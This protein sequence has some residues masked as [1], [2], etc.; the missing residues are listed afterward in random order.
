MNIKDFDFDLPEELIA[1]TPLEKRDSSKL[2]V[3]DRKT[4][5]MVDTHFDHILDELNPGDALVMN[6]TRV[7]PARLYGEKPDTHGHVEL[8]LLKNT[9][10]DQWEVLAKPAKRL[11]VGAKVS[12]GDGRLTATVKE[13]LDHGGRIVEFDYDGI[14]L[15]VLESLGEMPLPPYIH[16][17]LDDPER[18]QTVYAKENGSAAAPTAG[19]HFT[20]D[21]LEK[22]EAKGVKLVYLTLHVGL[23]TFRPVSVDNI[24]EHEMHSEFYTLSEEAAQTLRDVKAA[25]GRVVA[26]GTTSIRTLETI[27]SKFNGEIKADSGWTNIFIKPGYDFKVVDAFSTN[28]HLPKSTLVMLV[29]AFAGREFV[30][31]AYQHAIDQHYRFFSFGDA[32]FVK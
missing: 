32:M 10:G 7:L 24:D 12:F 29:S 14:F 5:D 6:N 21:L 23:G 22:I 13:E 26:V 19:L 4:H 20:Q 9:Q 31:E 30:L 18:Y 2:L 8:L 27:G 25:G 1:Q 15:E 11:R 3:I 16:E 17:K 28:F